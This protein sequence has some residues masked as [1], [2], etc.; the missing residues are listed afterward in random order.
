MESTSGGYLETGSLTTIHWLVVLLAL[1]TGVLHV[2]A[3]VVEG[4]IPVALAGVGFLGAV[5]LFLYGYRRHLLYPA[6]II[7]TAVQF[8]LWYVAKAGEY[9]AIG[10]VDKFLQAVLIVLLAYL[11]WRERGAQERDGHAMA[12]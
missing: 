2:Y 9:T 10:Y 6:G 5:A 1:V 3:G 11:Y 4:R 12:T 8:P 7:Y